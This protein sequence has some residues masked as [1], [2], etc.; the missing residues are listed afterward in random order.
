MRQFSFKVGDKTV[1]DTIEMVSPGVGLDVAEVIRMKSHVL[2]KYHGGSGEVLFRVTSGSLD[3]SYDSRLS[4]SIFNGD[5]IKLG[6]SVHKWIVGHNCFGG[7]NDVKGC[8]RYLVAVAE[9]RLGIKLPDWQEWEVNRVDIAHVFNM[10]SYAAVRDFIQGLRGVVYPRRTV[11]YYSLQGVYFPGRST[12]VK[13]YNKGLEFAVHDKNRLLKLK[14][15]LMY[16]EE[17]ILLL[18]K[19]SLL[20]LRVEVEV[21]RRKIKYDKKPLNCGLLD[22]SYFEDL[23]IKEVGKVINE[24]KSQVEVVRSVRD[25][26]ERLEICYGL[27]RANNLFSVWSR[28]QVEGIDVVKGDYSR[29]QWYRIKKGFREAGVSMFG[30]IEL[31]ESDRG[32][33]ISF[34][35]VPGNEG[36]V[37][38][39]FCDI[40]EAIG[41]LRIA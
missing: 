29:S 19:L 32:R 15:E 36:H 13:F 23:Y 27:R 1:Y 26:K 17:N 3:G 37:D 41:R 14:D 18:E 28:L 24:A 12:T 34:V 8:C 38:G 20:L 21:R 25:V 30:L 40:E 2:E 6:G 7:P 11:H 22:D 9:M 31:V 35:P 4:V 16:N 39:V 33:L 5:R 10:G